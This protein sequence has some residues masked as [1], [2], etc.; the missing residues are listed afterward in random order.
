[1]DDL[2]RFIAAMSGAPG[3][4]LLDSALRAE[5]LR[6]QTPGNPL[7]GYGLGFG[8]TVGDDGS[9]LAGHGGSVAGYTA[10]IAFDPDRRIG[11]ILLR[12]YNAGRT[13]L[14]AVANTLVQRLRA[15]DAAPTRD[16]AAAGAAPRAVRR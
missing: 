13:N 1:V 3:I 10:H 4:D 9:R 7:D 5:V 16:D 8:V 15:L 11:V 12:N 2:G 14:Q 6:V